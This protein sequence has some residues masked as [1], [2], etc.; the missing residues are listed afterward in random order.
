MIFLI[1][2]ILSDFEIK[3]LLYLREFKIN[4]LKVI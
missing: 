3:F 4:T 2:V 1:S